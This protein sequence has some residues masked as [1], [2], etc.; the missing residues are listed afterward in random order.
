MFLGA[1]GL[2]QLLALIAEQRL[3]QDQV[4]EM[5]KRLHVPGY[6][7]ARCHFNEAIGQLV[8]EPNTLAGFYWQ[9]NINAVLEWLKSTN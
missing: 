4:L 5:I 2:M 9:H 3:P 6:E 7:H 1:D 8:F